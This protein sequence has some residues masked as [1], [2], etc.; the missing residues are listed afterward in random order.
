MIGEHVEHDPDRG[1]DRSAQ[2]EAGRAL[3]E[4]RR[5]LDRRHAIRLSTGGRTG[6]PFPP[7]STTRP[8]DRLSPESRAVLSLV[9]LQSRSYGDIATL[10]RL[11]GDD[12]G[13]RGRAAG[14][15][16]G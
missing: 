7:V 10:L 2:G 1:R 16:L 4:V 11:G 8:L 9:L 5:R 13:D 6:V 3:L 12:G 14:G 15:G